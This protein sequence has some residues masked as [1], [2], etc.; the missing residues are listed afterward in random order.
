MNMILPHIAEISVDNPFEYE[1]NILERTNFKSKIKI[2]STMGKEKRSN[3]HRRKREPGLVQEREIERHQP[4][5]LT[6]ECD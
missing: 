5:R 2:L 3:R 4:V 6:E 1:K